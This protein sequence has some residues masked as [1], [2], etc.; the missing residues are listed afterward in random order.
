VGALEWHEALEKQLTTALS[1]RP[2]PAS[3]P[4]SNLGYHVPIAR[5]RAFPNSRK[6]E[7]LAK[8]D[9]AERW[10][11]APRRL[12]DWVLGTVRNRF[13]LD[14]PLR[15]DDRRILEGTLIPYLAS[16]PGFSRILFVGCDFYTTHYE[17]LFEGKEYWT[18]DKD[19]GRVKYGAR[20]HLVCRLDEARGHFAEGSLD[21][22]LMNGVLGWGLDL[23]AETEA[24]FAACHSCLRPGGVLLLGW[25]DTPDRLPFS[26]DESESLARFEPFVFPPLGVSSFLTK[27]PNRHTFSF[28]RKSAPR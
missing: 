25:N 1:E 10:R 24:S 21:L 8:G 20:R 14:A 11:T 16:A 7:S 22:I 13:G 2:F 19:P 9:A 27:N 4:P 15:T 28:Y 3:R 17:R 18:L 12:G 23:P 26:L 5:D 6:A